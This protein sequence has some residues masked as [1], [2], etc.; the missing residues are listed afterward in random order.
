MLETLMSKKPLVSCD[1]LSWEQGSPCQP[2]NETVAGKRL[3]CV[4]FQLSKKVSFKESYKNIIDRYT[5]K[6]QAKL[7]SQTE[8]GWEE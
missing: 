4:P 1:C 2:T 6:R 3:L 8:E 7:C 5:A